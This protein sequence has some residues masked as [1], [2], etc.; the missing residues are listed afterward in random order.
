M[1]ERLGLIVQRALNSA[2][3]S[4][5]LQPVEPPPSIVLES[6]RIAAH[7]DYS[8]NL[9]MTMASKQ[10][11]PPKEIAGTIIEHV[12]DSEH[13]ISRMEIAKLLDG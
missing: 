4:G 1:K 13:L 8:T 6:P 12:E 5:Y 2:F 9:A 7:G 3:S 11:R 10:K